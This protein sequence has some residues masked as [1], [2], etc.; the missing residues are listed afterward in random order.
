[1]KKALCGGALVLGGLLLAS[2]PSACAAGTLEGDGENGPEGAASD[3]DRSRLPPS[4]S[5]LDDAGAGRDAKA[6]ASPPPPAPGQSCTTVDQVFTRTCGACGTQSALCF[7]S[8]G[9]AGIVSEYNP[10]S[11]E[12]QG[13]CTAGTAEELACGNCGTQ[14]RKCST[15]CVWSV[16]TCV[17]AAAACKAGTVEYSPAGCPSASTY[18]M[19]TCQGTCAWT[20]YSAC[21]APVNETV[22]DVAGTVAQTTTRVVNLSA[23]QMAAGLEED[24][25]CP[26][27]Y[28]EVGNYPFRYVELRNLTG[29]AATVAIS[30]S[31]AANSDDLYPLFATYTLPIVPMT[32]AERLACVAG[33]TDYTA[34]VTI[35]VGQSILVYVSSYYEYDPSYPSESTGDV[36]LAVRTVSLL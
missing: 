11:G 4:A 1:M 8:D 30:I 13:G 7:S 21:A 36:T 29:K 9:G 16:G 20:P 32:Q 3:P 10:C 34:N 14:K 23:A 17:E 2:G 5:P 26:V 15:S 19:R 33:P 27:A 6:D 12:V 22:V 25:T 31:A 18:R 28:L 24:G 35:P